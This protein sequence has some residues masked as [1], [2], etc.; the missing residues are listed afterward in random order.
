MKKVI[1]SQRVDY[2]KNRNEY[3]DSV[4]RNLIRFL[5]SCNLIPVTISNALIADDKSSS[6]LNSWLQ[7]QD[8]SGIILSGGNNIGEF[9]ERD[10][11]EEFL[12]EYAKKSDFPLLGICRGM[13]MMAIYEGI[14]LKTVSG[15]VRI[16]HNLNGIITGKA[17]S[18]HDYSIDSCPD[19][20]QVAARSED[21]EIEA[22]QHKE[23]R[24]EGWMWHPER[25]NPFEAR[26]INRIKSIFSV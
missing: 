7:S 5:M 9:P 22:I 2:I 8:S 11:I 13:Q 4:D 15:H 26:D 24:W 18:Y 3:R 25:E 16:V 23:R 10:S 14:G 6:L 20:Y 21:G 12:I 17:N 1:V 19:N